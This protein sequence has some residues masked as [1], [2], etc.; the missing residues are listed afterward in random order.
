MSFIATTFIDKT[1]LIDELTFK[2]V[3]TLVHFSCVSVIMSDSDICT[4]IVM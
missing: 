3:T 1:T 2:R 4:H